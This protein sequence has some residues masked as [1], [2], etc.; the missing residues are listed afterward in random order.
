MPILEQKIANIKETGAAIAACACSG[1][2]V[3]IQGARQA[4]PRREDEGTSPTSWRRRS[5]RESSPSAQQ[6]H[7]AMLLQW[8]GGDGSSA[9]AIEY[10]LN[11][12]RRHLDLHSGTLF[13]QQHS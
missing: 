1:C 11:F 13:L 5:T 10:C 12:F 4:A 8:R 2:M 7:K 3:Q 6:D 9:V